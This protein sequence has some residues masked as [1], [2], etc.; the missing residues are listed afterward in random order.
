[1]IKKHDL[2]GVFLA[3]VTGAGLLAA[4]LLRAFVPRLIL[5]QL[6]ATA[7]VT[8][9]LI[10]L[11]LDHYIA[12]GSRRNYFLIPVYAALIFGIFPFAACFTAPLNAL[13]LA[14]LGAAAFTLATFL[15]DT[16]MDRLSSGPVA[17]AAPFVCVLGLFLA[18]QCLMGII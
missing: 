13:H 9:S 6:D 8:V 11:L 2:L 7:I 12:K 17:K 1:M 10:A 14:G 18:A 15:F 3:S 5:P 4:I 16:M